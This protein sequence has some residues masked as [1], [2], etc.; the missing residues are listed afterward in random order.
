MDLKTLNQLCDR[1][2]FL[3]SQLDCEDKKTRC[4]AMTKTL[5]K[6]PDWPDLKVGGWIEHIITICIE[7]NITTIEAER[8]FSRPIK[9]AYYRSIGV[10]PP[11]TIDVVRDDMEIKR[12]DLE[13]EL[14]DPWYLAT[15]SSWRRFLTE[16]GKTV[17]E[18]CNHPVDSHPDLSGDTR[19]LTLMSA[20]PELY[21]SNLMLL[22]AVQRLASGAKVSNL[23]EIML[24]AEKSLKK[25]EGEN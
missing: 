15:G 17:C 16:S 24:F 21:E 10:T 3:S 22:D 19:H 12:L 14:K 11:K 8:D 2:D 23:D 25:A 18:P 20:S 5:L 7:S 13:K 9:H 6:N 1:A 4:L